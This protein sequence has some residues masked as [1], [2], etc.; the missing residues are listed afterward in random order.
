[1][2]D[3]FSYIRKKL[4][5]W[6]RIN[7]RNF[8]WRHT[9]DP[10]KIMIAEFM[11][12]RTKAEQVVPIYNKFIEKYPDIFSLS[13]AEEK[14]IKKFTENLGLH[15]RYRHFIE[16]SRFIIKNYGQIFPDKLKDLSKVP[17]IGEYISSAIYIIAFN[18][19]APV[20]DSNIARF[21]N[22]F[23]NLKLEGEI[24][25]K[26]IIK[27][28]SYNLFNTGSCAELLFAVIDFCSLICKPLNPLC[29]ECI[30]FQKCMYENKN[31]KKVIENRLRLN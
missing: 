31:Y 22:R 18:K 9:N 27:Q 12:H 3:S 21:L 20:V 24:R 2:Q 8:P 4:L 1:M 15:W 10:Y 26:K 17:G 25:R 13:M 5:R 19:N 6:Y 29:A 7:G 23:F 30:F 28:L 14:D 11:L 16:S